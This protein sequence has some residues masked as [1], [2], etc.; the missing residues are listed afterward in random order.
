MAYRKAYLAVHYGFDTQFRVAVDDVDLFW[1]LT[2]SGRKLGF[3][4]AAMGWHHRRGP[5]R[6]Y[7]KQQRGYGKAE[8]LLE[9]KCPEKYNAAGHV[10][11]AGRVYGNG[12][13]RR[14]WSRGR[15]YQGMWG[16]A[17]FQSIYEPAAGL[18]SSLPLMPEWYLLMPVLTAASMLA[19]LWPALAVAVPLLV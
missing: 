11:W 5:V 1:R 6:T 12:H 9:S 17:P 15:I 8:A 14:I 7:W 16:C 2:Q 3:W 13:T 18:V 10:S 19:L 4:P